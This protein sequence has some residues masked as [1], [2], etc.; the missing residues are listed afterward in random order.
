MDADLGWSSLIGQ[1]DVDPNLP[2]DPCRPATEPTGHHVSI[3]SVTYVHIPTI[4]TCSSMSDTI[5]SSTNRTSA[6]AT[7]R[8]ERARR[9][10]VLSAETD[11]HEN[12]T[13]KTRTTKNQNR[14]KT[15]PR[16]TELTP[17]VPRLHHTLHT[18]HR[19][20]AAHLTTGAPVL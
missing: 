10:G 8:S 1:T 7:G 15:E 5:A 6:P 16:G 19:P 12:Q 18:R 9:A 20:S 4:T 11:D 14:T 3:S 17:E 13:Q 2:P